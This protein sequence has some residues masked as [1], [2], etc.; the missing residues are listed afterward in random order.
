[1][2]IPLNAVGTIAVVLGGM[3]TCETVLVSICGGGNVE[4]WLTCNGDGAGSNIDVG[5]IG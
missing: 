3:V 5:V 1:M 2:G 4:I